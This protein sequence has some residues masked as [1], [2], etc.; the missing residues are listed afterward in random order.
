MEY[1][2]GALCIILVKPHNI[3]QVF[4]LW[5]MMGANDDWAWRLTHS[6]TRVGGRTW[7]MEST[8]HYRARK[9]CKMGIWTQTVWL[10]RLFSSSLCYAASNRQQ[11]EISERVSNMPKEVDIKLWGPHC[12]FWLKRAD[13]ETSD[14]FAGHVCRSLWVDFPAQTSTTAW[15]D[16]SSR[17]LPDPSKDRCDRSR[18][19]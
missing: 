2:W 19:N 16:H 10:Q 17:L 5:L 14:F 11:D 18:H 4:P 1:V 13:T 8:R 6:L 9:W 12:C 3:P 7:G 15:K